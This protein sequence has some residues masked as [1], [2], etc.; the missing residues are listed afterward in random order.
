MAL[1]FGKLNFSTSFNPTSAFPLD[2]R[3][4]FE[5]YELAVAAAATAEEVG[6]STTTYF[7]GETL[8][9]YD[10]E[11]S[12]VNLY[13][14]TPEK[15]L[16]AVGSTVLGDDKSIEINDGKI[17]IKGLSTAEEGAQLVVS[18]GQ[19]KWV[20]P[21]TTTVEGLSTAVS[22][23]QQ[24]V[25][26]TDSGLV[27][28]VNDLK[29]TV[30]GHGTRLTE[31]E[32]DITILQGQIQGL[33]GAVHFKGKVDEL[34]ETLDDYNAGD[35]ILVGTKEYICQEDE[36]VKSW[37]ELG[38]EGTHLT[39]SQAQQYFV[40]LERTING[41]PLS[42][43]V[44]LAA[45]D[46][47]G[48]E[49]SGTAQGLINALDMAEVTVGATKTLA[50]IKQENGLVTATAVDIAIPHTAITDWTT[51]LAKKQDAIV[52]EGE[53]FLKKTADGWTVDNNEYL[54]LHAKADTAATADKVANKLIIGS[55]E[56]NGSA[57]ITVTATD[58]GALTTIPQA[59][60]EVLGGIKLGHAETATEKAVKLDG[61][62]KAYV[63][64][65]AALS[66]TAGAG[67][68]LTGTEFKIKEQGVEDS[69]IKGVNVSKL[70]QTPG[71][72]LILNGG[73]AN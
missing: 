36:G 59:T 67:L 39:L 44:V 71:D 26:D 58:F 69:M 22:A 61:E 72:T 33:T 29:T 32:E 73:N 15:T 3:T 20:K 37:V 45:S 24:T 9:V 42:A 14:I 19:V 31:A 51:E 30:A 40:P 43:N 25:G 38:D 4:Y 27:K 60:E 8:A 68:E 10:K 47:E 52:A 64:I 48:I 12:T 65:P 56:F 1:D 46:I 55:K 6:S 16:K 62:G 11:A 34:P 21:D 41:K 13:Q 35:V 50:S 18:N 23:L 57:E 66:Y 5:S 2:A 63:E 54:G 7:Y 49:A 17:S 53:G 70:E 28:D